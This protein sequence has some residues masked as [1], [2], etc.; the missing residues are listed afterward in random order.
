[1]LTV[2]QQETLDFIK[3]YFSANN[4]TPTRSEMRDHFGLDNGAISWRL[5]KLAENNLIERIPNT[6]RNIRLV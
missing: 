3:A 4:K 1:M 2:K 5:N 6:W